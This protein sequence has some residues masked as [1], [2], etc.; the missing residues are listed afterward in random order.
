M[1]LIPANVEICLLVYNCNYM[2][3]FI[4]VEMERNLIL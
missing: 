1:V 4:R 3:Y 2:A